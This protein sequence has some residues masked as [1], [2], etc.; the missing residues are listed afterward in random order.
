VD[1]ATLLLLALVAVAPPII[2]AVR[3]RNAERTRREPWRA[4]ARAFLWGAVAA[5][6]ISILLESM[7]R[8]RFDAV[9]V[10]SPRLTLTIVILSPVVEELLKAIGLRFLRDEDP[11]AEDGYIYGGAV[12]LG[13]AATENVLYVF[14]AWFLAG[15]ETAIATALFRGIATTCLH[16]AASAI[17]GHGVWRA[18]YGGGVGWALWGV[19][20]G[21]VLHVAYNA[22]AAW[23]PG[24][25]TLGAALVAVLAYLR[26]MRRVRVL[27]ERGLGS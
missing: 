11:E 3:L 8:P 1:A 10:L 7:L 9:H 27:D 25:A 5:A 22:L 15:P 24:W 21:I 26:M 6:G 4:L 20:A 12:G 2:L 17:A 23:T 19:G 13:F 18:R 16:G 14:T